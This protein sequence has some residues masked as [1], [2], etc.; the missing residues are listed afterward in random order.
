MVVEEKNMGRLLT[1][2]DQRKQLTHPHLLSPRSYFTKPQP[3]PAFS[4]THDSK[5]EFYIE[6]SY[7]SR[8]LEDVIEDISRR[9]GELSEAEIRRIFATVVEVLKYLG[10]KG[11]C[12]GDIK[13]SN[14]LYDH[15]GT[16]KLIDSYFVSGGKTAYQIVMENPSSMSLL[17]PEQLQRIRDRQFEDISGIHQS[18]VFAVGLS[19][20]EV[21]TFE[22]AMECY[23]LHSLTLKP[24]YHSRKLEELKQTSYSPQL[25]QLAMACIAEQP[26]KRPSLDHLLKR[27]R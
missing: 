12:H 6:Y 4:C 27:I 16:I 24:D 20:L 10:E 18:E 9:G 5:V 17:S 2:L 26:S 25:V 3:A 11:S 19:M 7:I 8:T 1:L 15:L 13:P 22:P 23:N 14:I 21:M